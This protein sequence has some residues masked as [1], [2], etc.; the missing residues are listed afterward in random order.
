[1]EYNFTY[2]TIHYFYEY[3]SV[4]FEECQVIW[5]RTSRSKI[6][7]KSVTLKLIHMTHM[8][9]SPVDSPGALMLHYTTPT[10][11]NAQP[12]MCHL[13]YCV[14][15]DNLI[16]LWLAG[17]GDIMLLGPCHGALSSP[18]SERDPWI[19]LA[20]TSSFISPPVYKLFWDLWGFEKPLQMKLT[21]LRTIES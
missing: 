3:S 1:M 11:G 5:Q 7:N 17:C 13:P 19:T 8:L 2:S 14:C 10:L 16:L 6:Q 20:W 15:V 4:D 9:P 18:A 21:A 12:D